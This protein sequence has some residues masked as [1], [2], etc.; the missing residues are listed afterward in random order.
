V[1]SKA[2]AIETFER[3]G[4]HPLCLRQIGSTIYEYTPTGEQVSQW[5]AGFILGLPITGIALIEYQDGSVNT[6]AKD[7][8]LIGGSRMERWPFPSTKPIDDYS[9]RQL[10]SAG[11]AMLSRARVPLV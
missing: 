9:A 11:S 2:E 5:Q 3:E 7:K 4:H 8:L 1:L 6:R 10:A